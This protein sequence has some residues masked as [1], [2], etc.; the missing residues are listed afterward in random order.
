M[1]DHS[2][3]TA[4]NPYALETAQDA[5]E[6]FEIYEP[7]PENFDPCVDKP[8]S[9][10]IFQQGD[11]RIKMG[12]GTVVFTFGSLIRRRNRYYCRNAL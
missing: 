7:P 8:V 2:R 6:C 5:S 1:E 11:R 4:K 12:V 9:K 10:N 3:S